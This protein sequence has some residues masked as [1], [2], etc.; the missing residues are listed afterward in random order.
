MLPSHLVPFGH[1]PQPL[2]AVQLELHPLQS[3]S[4]QSLLFCLPV[5][6][7]LQ[8]GHLLLAPLQGSLA[9]PV[10]NRRGGFCVSFALINPRSSAELSQAFLAD[11]V[12]LP[13]LMLLLFQAP[14]TQDKGTCQGF[15]GSDTAQ[16]CQAA[17]GTTAEN[18]EDL[19]RSS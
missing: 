13:Q 15:P 8:V 5:G 19:S 9:L 1:L 6:F 18:W 3:L 17:K 4:Q 14:A 12:P 7:I 16:P 11:T 2:L 10:Q